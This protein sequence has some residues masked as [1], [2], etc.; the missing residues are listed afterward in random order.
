MLRVHFAPFAVSDGVRQTGATSSRRRLGR[1]ARHYVRNYVDD[2]I[3]IVGALAGGRGV[4]WRTRCGCGHPAPT[5]PNGSELSVPD[6]E[7]G[8]GGGVD[9]HA[10]ITQS[11]RYFR[12]HRFAHGHVTD[13]RLDIRD[14]IRDAAA[15]RVFVRG[16]A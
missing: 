15:V 11:D 6:G 8:P 5:P 2:T 3:K 7:A 16:E 12:S 1:H 9:F 13:I 10:D 4:P 14:V